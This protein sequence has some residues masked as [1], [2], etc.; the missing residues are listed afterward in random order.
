MQ[1]FKVKGKGLYLILTLFVCS[2]MVA[3]TTDALSTYTPYSLFG[4]GDVSRPGTAFNKSMGSIGIGVKDMRY[5]NYLNP[6]SIVE[7]DSFV[8]G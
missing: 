5:I 3:Q 8:Y 7:R 4:V 2:K 6:A 1:S